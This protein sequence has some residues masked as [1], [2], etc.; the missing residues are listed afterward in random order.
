MSRYRLKPTSDQELILL[1]HCGDARYVWNLCV[2]Q[3]NE[4]RPGRGRTPGLAER[5]RQLTEA[6]AE[7]PWLAEGSA[8]V[9]QQA[10]RDHANAMQAFFNGTHGKPG[11][12]KAGKHEAFRIVGT[13]GR[14]WD[15]RRLNRKVG[16]V[17]IAKVGWVRFRWSRAVPESVKSFRVT[18][19]TAPAAGMS[20]SST[21]PTR[22]PH[23]ATGK[24]S[25]STVGTGPRRPPPASPSGST[26]S[27]LRTCPST[28]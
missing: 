15:V 19:A 24:S 25:G 8:V 16:E 10:I 22:S 27:A 23:L 4:Y 11:W 5:S 20:R 14:A 17:F 18:R 21:F 9:Q 6:R 12:R 1:R 13:R 26:W 3:E 7:N 28:R 2:E